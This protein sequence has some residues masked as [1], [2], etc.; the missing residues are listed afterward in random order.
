[1]IDWSWI[2]A[3][4]SAL[5]M[6]LLSGIGIYAVLL[7]M[8]RIA[9]LRSFSKMSSFDFA[10]TVALGSVVAS[11]ILAEDPPLLTGAFGLIVL[12]GLQYLLSRFRRLTKAV[13]RLV[14]NEPL[15]VMAGEQVLTDHLDQARMTE[16]DLRSKLR[17]A[18][19]THPKQVLAVIFETGG[20]VSVIKSTDEVDPWLFEDV[21]GAEAL[22]F[23]L[24]HA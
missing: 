1:M 5:L 2:T 4:G 12:Y 21:R 18:G 23:P 20:D 7:L 24:D 22:S 10:I 13:E 8:T 3:T 16:D 15:I 14:D 6:V 11:T 17:M 19:V 9:G